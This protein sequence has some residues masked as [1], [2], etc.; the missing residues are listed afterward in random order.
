MAR[1]RLLKI[2]RRILI[3]SYLLFGG[4][5]RSR[6]RSGLVERSLVGG[7]GNGRASGKEK[8]G[9]RKLHGVV[10]DLSRLLLYDFDEGQ[11][12]NSKHRRGRKRQTSDHK[13]CVIERRRG[14]RRYPY[15]NPRAIT[16]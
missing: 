4:G 2:L 8:D 14:P 15:G 12:T 5:L 11:A 6:K 7:E 1:Q 16:W 3:Q 10:K 13:T 9:S